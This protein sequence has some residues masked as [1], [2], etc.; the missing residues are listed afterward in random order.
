MDGSQLLRYGMQI[1]CSFLCQLQLQ[2]LQ[3]L[4]GLGTKQSRFYLQLSAVCV[5]VCTDRSNTMIFT[6]SSNEVLM[7]TQLQGQIALLQGKVMQYEPQ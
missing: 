6:P 3:L 4:S 5:C 1:L 7:V 2:A